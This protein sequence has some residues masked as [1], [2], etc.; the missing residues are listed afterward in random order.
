[1]FARNVRQV[2]RADLQKLVRGGVRYAQSWLPP[3]WKIPD[4]YL[5]IHPDGG[6]PGFALPGEQGFDFFQVPRNAAG[7]I[8]WSRLVGTISHECHHLGMRTILPPSLSPADEVAFRFLTFFVGEGTATKFISKAPGGCVPAVAAVKYP[9]P[10]SG[11]LLAAWKEHTANE[12]QVFE[13]LV[14]TF[15]KAAAGEMNASD[16]DKEVPRWVGGLVG[17][18]Y[19]AGA[20][21]FGA[22]YAAFGKPGVF[23][24]I[25]DPRTIFDS[26][27]K[28][29]DK[30][31]RLLGSCPRIPAK[32]VELALAIGRPKRA[33]R[34]AAPIS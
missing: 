25:E 10:F 6:S 11:E 5:C 21:L 23:A 7:D 26:Y 16:L 4:F 13:R 8:E 34:G 2:V 22:I 1:L 30:E 18:A 32:T 9:T 15:D 17:P 12:N 27:N 29:I 28:A 33:L 14:A 20:E 19:F 24:A 3:G 31:P